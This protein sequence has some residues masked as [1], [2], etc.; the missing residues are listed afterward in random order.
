MSLIEFTEKNPK[1]FYDPAEFQFL[2]PI[3]DNFPVFKYEFLELM[4]IEKEDQWLKTFPDYVK[5]EKFKAWKVF[6]FIFFYMKFPEHA[7]LPKTC[8]MQGKRLPR[9]AASANVAV[10]PGT[11]AF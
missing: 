4:K 2:K 10:M 11:L 6:S 1:L 5:S 7:K 9:D 3:T 8:A